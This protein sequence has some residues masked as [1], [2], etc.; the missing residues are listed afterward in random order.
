[1][2]YLPALKWVGQVLT[3]QLLLAFFQFSPAR[4]RFES[5]SLDMIIAY[6]ILS[7]LVAGLLL[8][9]TIDEMLPNGRG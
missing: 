4:W 8:L 2:R 6:I 7:T 3:F 9:R 5:P 1:M